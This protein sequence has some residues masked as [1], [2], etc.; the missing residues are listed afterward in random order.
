MYHIFMLFSSK[1]L[2]ACGGTS[3][4]LNTDNSIQSQSVWTGSGGGV[5]SFQSVPSWQSQKQLYYTTYS[6]TGVIGNPSM[7]AYRG[8]PDFSAPADPYTGYQFYT[9]GTLQTNGGTSAAAPFLAGL[10]AVI[11]QNLGSKI[12]FNTL[13]P[14][15]YANYSAFYD[16]TAGQN[17]QD[18]HQ[19]GIPNVDGYKATIG[20]DAATGLGSPYG[21]SILGLLQGTPTPPPGPPPPPPPPGNIAGY[22]WPRPKIAWPGYNTPDKP[23]FQ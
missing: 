12:S 21:N 6:S 7:L 10:F 19:L 3:L 22:L 18:W 5:S 1:Y 11:I 2:I 15:I 17:N 9:Q 23:I 13:M 20:W 16:I 14:L 4:H 8:V